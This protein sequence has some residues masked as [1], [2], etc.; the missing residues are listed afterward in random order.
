MK[1]DE[2]L[3]SLFEKFTTYSNDEFSLDEDYSLEEL[4][5]DEEYDKFV[6]DLTTPDEGIG[7]A[8]TTLDLYNNNCDEVIEC[9]AAEM[10]VSFFMVN[11]D[12]FKLSY[13]ISFSDREYIKNEF[14]TLAEMEDIIENNNFDDYYFNAVHFCPE[15]LS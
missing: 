8:Y 4:L 11:D 6:K 1:Q 12:Y 15:N 7:L 3:Y 10:Q 14:Y 5:C 13:T 9:E 2:K